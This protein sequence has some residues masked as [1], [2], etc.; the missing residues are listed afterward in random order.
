MFLASYF[1]LCRWAL[2]S[3]WLS[4]LNYSALLRAFFFRISFASQCVCD[5][6]QAQ[7]F[8]VFEDCII[9]IWSNTFTP[10]W[11][12]DCV[13]FPNDVLCLTEV[14]ISS[15]FD[16]FYLQ[17]CL[18]L[19][20][21]QLFWSSPPGSLWLVH[22]ILHLFS[23]LFWETSAWSVSPRILSTLHCSTPTW[24]GGEQFRKLRKKPDR[25]CCLWNVTNVP[26]L[27]SWN[28]AGFISQYFA[29]VYM[30]LHSVFSQKNNWR[31]NSNIRISI[32]WF[33]IQKLC[34]AAATFVYCY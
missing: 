24:N 34:C 10:L 15:L 6:W 1:T 28:P 8:Q 29:S 32:S 17:D 7:V 3:L 11:T 13:E 22:S 19:K 4:S 25:K 30:S 18:C 23:H 9:C 26:F 12:W 2:V 14:L 33:S 21:Q 20:K 16:F 31:F 5:P 27:P